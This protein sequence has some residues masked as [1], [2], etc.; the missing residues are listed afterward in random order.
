MFGADLWTIWNRLVSLL[1]MKTTLRMKDFYFKLRE[2]WLIQHPAKFVLCHS[3]DYLRHYPGIQYPFVH[4]P[5]PSFGEKPAGQ[6]Q[7]IPEKTADPLKALPRL[8]NLL[9]P[10]STRNCAFSLLVCMYCLK[11]AKQVVMA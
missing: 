8:H 7:M 5:E 4:R 1:V 3:I 9:G 6:G 10:E 2:N 11:Q